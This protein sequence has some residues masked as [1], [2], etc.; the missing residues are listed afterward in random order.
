MIGG[1]DG[2]ERPKGIES[3]MIDGDDGGTS[4]T[5]SASASGDSSCGKTCGEKTPPP[6]SSLLRSWAA[7]RRLP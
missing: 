1:C 3:E 4:E 2:C 6:F 5:E 7:S